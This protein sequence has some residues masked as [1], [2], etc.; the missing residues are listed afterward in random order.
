MYAVF[1][2]AQNL[3]AQLNAAIALNIGR[4]ARGAGHILEATLAKIAAGVGL[5]A[6]KPFAHVELVYTDLPLA[7]DAQVA[8]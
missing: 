3:T 6:L 7:P 8:A 4:S 1:V 5:P 2:G